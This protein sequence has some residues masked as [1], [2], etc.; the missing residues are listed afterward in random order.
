MPGLVRSCAGAPCGRSH[1]W[2]CRARPNGRDLCSKR[3]ES[4]E[5]CRRRYPQPHGQLRSRSS[6]VSC[7]LRGSGRLFWT[8][9]GFDDDAG[10]CD[11]RSKCFGISRARRRG[12]SNRRQV[13]RSSQSARSTQ[14]HRLQRRRIRAR[15]VQ[16][17]HSHGRRPAPHHRRDDHCGLCCRRAPGLHLRSRRVSLRLQGHGRGGG[18]SAAGR[19]HWQKYPRLRIG[20]RY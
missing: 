11:R 6:H 8:K 3:A 5:L 10:R 16:R 4:S 20:F 7:R 12:I 13:G 15:D 19:H 1:S 2:T 17:P 9:E 18:G 14:V